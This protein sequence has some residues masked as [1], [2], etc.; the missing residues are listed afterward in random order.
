MADADGLRG[1]L[2]HLRFRA[3]GLVQQIEQAT[4]Q[5]RAFARQYKDLRRQARER[6]IAARSEQLRALGI[7]RQVA[8]L[9]VELLKLERRVD[10]FGM[11]GPDPQIKASLRAIAAMI[12]SYAC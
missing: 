2:S 11:V 1:D 4:A 3:E 8:G 7:G 9:Q 5:S 6:M 10:G 12:D